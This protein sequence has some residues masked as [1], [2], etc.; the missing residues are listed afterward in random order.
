MGDILKFL[1]YGVLGLAALCAVYASKLLGDQLKL[2][3]EERTTGPIFWYMGAVALLALI[4]G[5]FRWLEMDRVV[6]WKVEGTVAKINSDDHSGIQIEV[7]PPRPSTTTMRPSGS[8]LIDGVLLKPGEHPGLFIQA[9]GYEPVDTAN[10]EE[11]DLKKFVEFDDA[12]NLVHIKKLILKK[13]QDLD[14]SDLE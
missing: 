4:A 13:Q 7:V 11:G 14:F 1:D 9:P 10:M 3:K 12:K 6:T 8:F 2:K 5:G